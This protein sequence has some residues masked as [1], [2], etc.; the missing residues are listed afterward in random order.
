M[1][2]KPKRK[3]KPKHNIM[4]Y[5]KDY[6]QYCKVHGV[7]LTDTIYI[8]DPP[9]HITF[10]SLGGSSNPAIHHPDNLITL[11]RYHHDCAHRK[12]KG[13]Y[14]SPE[15]LREVKRIEEGNNATF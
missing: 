11:C 1:F 4:Q 8:I 13:H 12:V 10:K 14:I 15:Q 2:P 5:A 3:P 7:L 6:C 9:H